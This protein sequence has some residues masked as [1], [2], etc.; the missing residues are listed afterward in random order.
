MSQDWTH[1]GHLELRRRPSRALDLT[2]SL[3][4]ELKRGLSQVRRD[5]HGGPG[6]LS[7][8]TEKNRVKTLKS[9]EKRVQEASPP[10][11]PLHHCT[12]PLISKAQQLSFQSS[13]VFVCL[14]SPFVMF[15]IKLKPLAFYIML[16]LE[17]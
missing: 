16:E 14:F 3:L 12:P 6:T 7:S 9:H 15:S 1:E 8:I 4:T 13:F 2:F 10:N 17:P 5:R 11:P